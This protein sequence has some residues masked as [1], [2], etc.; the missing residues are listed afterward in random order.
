MLNAA[1][2]PAPT[3]ATRRRFHAAIDDR[4]E[5]E[6]ERLRRRIPATRAP[7]PISPPV[8]ASRPANARAHRPR[9][10][11][12]RAGR[13]S[14]PDSGRGRRRW[15]SDWRRRSGHPA[16]I[17]E[18][19][20]PVAPCGGVTMHAGMRCI[21]GIRIATAA[22]PSCRS[23]LL[24]AR[25]V[26]ARTRPRR[27]RATG[28]RATSGRS[29]TL[30]AQ[31][32]VGIV[33]GPRR[34]HRRARR[35]APTTSRSSTA[36]RSSGNGATTRASESTLDCEPYEA[37][38]SADQAPRS[39]SSTSSSAPGRI[40]V[41]FRLKQRDKA[42]G[43]AH[44]DRPGPAR[45][46]A[47]L[48]VELALERRQS[49]RRDFDE[50]S[51]DQRVQPAPRAGPSLEARQSGTAHRGYVASARSRRR[52]ARAA[53]ADASGRTRRPRARARAPRAGR[54]M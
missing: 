26:A 14:T 32:T 13:T 31:P 24:S 7:A 39:R 21:D 5:E 33:A 46:R 54:L 12:R 16:I 47:S 41:Y 37:G 9:T 18:A 48:L 28:R 1:T 8:A 3:S 15:T 35:A 17:A 30:R 45:G 25:P 23:W 51:V 52:R 6:L 40:R 38:K 50:P 10:R 4:R 29:S 20:L 2:G 43:T 44:R 27:R 49:R 22:D 36:R 11:E 42:V 34:P 19:R 53:S